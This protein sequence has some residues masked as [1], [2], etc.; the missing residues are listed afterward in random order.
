[1]AHDEGR[2][3]VLAAADSSKRT[4]PIGTGGRMV[5]AA[6]AVVML[7][8]GLW[9]WRR[10]TS[11]APSGRPS[12][13]TSI[14][15]YQ[16]LA[17]A[18]ARRAK[19]PSV[20]GLERGVPQLV[21]G[22]EN[23]KAG[24]CVSLA[25]DLC[26]IVFDARWSQA[27]CGLYIASR[28][29][30]SGPFGNLH[31]ISGCNSSTLET[32][33]LSLSPSGL[34]LV[35]RQGGQLFYCRRAARSSEFATPDPWPVPEVTGGG[36][37]LALARF[38]N[39]L[40]VLISTDTANANP[41]YRF[42]LAERADLRSAFGPPQEIALRNA[43]GPR[44][45]LRPDL[46]IAYAGWDVGLALLG[47]KSEKEEFG[48]VVSLYPAAVCGRVAGPIWVTPGEDVAFYCSPGPGD[49]LGGERYIWMIRF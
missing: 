37:R 3:E 39:D 43:P 14:S 7:A 10:Y 1:M 42:F 2:S 44:L 47:R 8:A 32:S 21:P 4:R 17:T 48:P 6:A 24:W 26:T 12:G 9:T 45:C 23:V 28:P 35:F 29:S 5:I 15:A 20:P 34:E 27:P 16:V 11:S 49:R 40:R 36:R 33:N 38:L 31:A 46:L 22:L 13:T 41:R 30:M 19:I 25:D 18:A